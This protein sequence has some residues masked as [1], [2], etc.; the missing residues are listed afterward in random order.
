V[1][2]A[3]LADGQILGCTCSIETASPD[4]TWSCEVVACPEQL[5]DEG[6]ECSIY[7]LG[8]LCEGDVG[9]CECQWDAEAWLARFRC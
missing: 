1:C 3:R 7:L 2:T 4:P 8:E 6:D 9:V 5:P